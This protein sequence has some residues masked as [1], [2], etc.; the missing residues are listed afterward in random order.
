MLVAGAVCAGG[1]GMLMEAWLAIGGGDGAAELSGASGLMPR[2]V[3]L[4]V[5]LGFSWL[6]SCEAEGLVCAVAASGA[7]L[8]APAMKVADRMANFDI[9]RMMSLLREFRYAHSTFF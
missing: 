5:P 2:V 4:S 8:I 7:A 1:I 9:V 6:M 3:S